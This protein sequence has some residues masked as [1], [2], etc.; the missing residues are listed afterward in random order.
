MPRKGEN[1]YK[2]KDG[3][4]EGRYIKGHNKTNRI[5]YGY[6]YAYTYKE[7]KEKLNIAKSGIDSKKTVTEKKIIRIGELCALRWKNISL[8]E[9]TIKIESTLQRLQIVDDD[10]DNKTKIFI[11]RKDENNETQ[12]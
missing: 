9:Q 7:V 5:L 8:T 2:R 10:K 12:P 1:I 6:I 3:R 4:W 11:L